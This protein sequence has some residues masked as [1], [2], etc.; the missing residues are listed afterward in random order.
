MYIMWFTRRYTFLYVLQSH[1]YRIPRLSVEY[2]CFA[3]TLKGAFTYVC[4]RHVW[5]LVKYVHC[6][7]K[8]IIQYFILHLQAATEHSTALQALSSLASHPAA[9]LPSWHQRGP[10]ST[11][12]LTWSTFVTEAPIVPTATP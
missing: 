1:I 9:T 8:T 4:R 11:F 3:S 6:V 2:K 12:T 10:S 7:K 5:L